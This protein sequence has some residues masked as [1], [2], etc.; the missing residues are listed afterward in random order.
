MEKKARAFG[1]RKD[2]EQEKD[3]RKNDS[4]RA[5]RF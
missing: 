3:N 2:K 5:K 1:A 4:N